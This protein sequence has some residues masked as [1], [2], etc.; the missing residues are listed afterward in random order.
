MS[1][2]GFMPHIKLLVQDEWRVLRDVRLA[3]LRE[4]PNSFLAMYENEKV[5]DELKWRAE[6]SRGDWTVSMHD[7][8]LAGIVGCTREASTPA[9]E[10]YLEYLWV[11]PLWRNKGV[12]RTM[13]TAVLDRLRNSGVR[14]AYLWVLDG[15]DAAVRLYKRVGFISSNHRH[16]PAPAGPRSS[17][18]STWADAA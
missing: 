11:A 14:T 8:Q 15:N 1:K 3:A 17:C 12:A 4:S 9:D 16:R 6:F 13:V 10:R 5:F 7:E 18:S 2:L